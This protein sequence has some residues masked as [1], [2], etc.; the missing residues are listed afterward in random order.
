MTQ[1]YGV[2]YLPVV[3]ER[4]EG[5]SL[6]TGASFCGMAEGMPSDLAMLFPDS[7]NAFDK[8][9]SF[10]DFPPLILIILRTEYYNRRSLDSV[11]DLV[12][13]CDYICADKQISNI[14]R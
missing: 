13:A 9:S 1:R 7:P 10:L 12:V 14:G 8:R 4:I 11:S 2:R 6:T 3:A 5:A